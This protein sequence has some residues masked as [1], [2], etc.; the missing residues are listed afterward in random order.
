MAQ[1]FLIRITKTKG[2]RKYVGRPFLCMNEWIWN[3]LPRSLTETYPM[4]VYGGVLHSL[5]KFRSARTQYHGTFFLRNR[6]ELELMRS[7]VNQKGKG[8]TL[9]LLVLGCSNG[10]EVYS[11]SWT[12]R[13]ARPDLQVIV[14]AVDI[15]PDILE[16]A[17]RGLY[18]I[19]ENKLVNAPIFER[20]TEN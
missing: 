9:R 16:I 20:L 7:L 6:P 3:R 17:K 1:S 8:S 2:L 15:S 11:L 14:N 5:V 18:S 19:R 13:S 4:S 10:A 12:I